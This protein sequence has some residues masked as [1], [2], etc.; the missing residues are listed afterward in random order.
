ML[1]NAPFNNSSFNFKDTKVY[2]LLH[3]STAKLKPFI[4][5]IDPCQAI[6]ML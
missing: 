1:I 4:N 6:A 2:A 3:N 5:P